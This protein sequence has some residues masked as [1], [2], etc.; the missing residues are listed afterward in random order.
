MIKG[1]KLL[2]SK[3]KWP[4][5]ST[6]HILYMHRNEETVF[7]TWPDRADDITIPDRLKPPSTNTGS[8]SGL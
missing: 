2:Q 5:A 6:A 4:P 3:S 7:L 1:S 8:C